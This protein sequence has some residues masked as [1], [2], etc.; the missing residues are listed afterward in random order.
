MNSMLIPAL[1]AIAGAVLGGIFFG[2]LWWTVQKGVSS[3]Q[4]ALLFISSWL[5]RTIIVTAGFYCITRGHL[6]RLPASLIGF[7]L[8]RFVVMR[9]TDKQPISQHLPVHGA[10]HEAES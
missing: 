7:T 2:G 6:D 5:L 9:G 8:A 4:P 1:A 3:R 10:N